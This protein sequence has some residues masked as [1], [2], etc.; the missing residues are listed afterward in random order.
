MTGL[1]ARRRAGASLGQL[2]AQTGIP[3]T[4]LLRKFVELGV[5]PPG[6]GEPRLPGG[7]TPDQITDIA[8]RYTGGASERTV[9]AQTGLSRTVV[10]AALDAT[11]MQR[12]RSPRSGR[13]WTAGL[14]WQIVVRRLAGQMVA[15]I[16]T[17]TGMSDFA[18]A[19]RLADLKIDKGG[20]CPP[21]WRGRV[22]AHQHRLTEDL[23]DRVHEAWMAAWRALGQTSMRS[24]HH[25]GELMIPYADLAEVDKDDD[26]RLV[27]AV[28]AGLAALPEHDVLLLLAGHQTGHPQPAP[29]P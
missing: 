9:A 19:V 10:R 25:T 14:T 26:R 2:T 18:V 7:L 1:V 27:A 23:A 17:A 22:E 13:R 4:T 20:P 24:R 5:H 16:A 8:R 12:R 3:S 6:A 28:L 21:A 29:Q 15:Q 11:G